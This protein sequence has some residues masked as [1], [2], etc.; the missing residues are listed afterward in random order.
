MKY[1][2]WRC[3]ATAR[4]STCGER[5]AL[6]P[7]PSGC[8]A[9]PLGLPPLCASL[10]IAE[11]VTEEADSTMCPIGRRVKPN[12]TAHAACDHRYQMYRRI[13]ECLDPLWDD[14]C[15]CAGG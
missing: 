15:R 10:D 2:A 7:G 4:G 13:I 12:K 14:L 11:H 3:A 5:T 1:W 6:K 8:P 9:G